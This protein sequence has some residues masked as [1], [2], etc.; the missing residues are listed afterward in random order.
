MTVSPRI[1]RIEE[2]H[3]L[4]IYLAAFKHESNQII[5]SQGGVAGGGQCFV[6]K[7]GNRL[8]GFTKN[9]GVIGVSRNT[10]DTVCEELFQCRNVGISLRIGLYSNL[11]PLCD[12]F[13]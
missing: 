11:F 8:V 3:C 6:K 2:F 9:A 4:E 13:F 1:G 7:V 10:L 5:Y 12:K